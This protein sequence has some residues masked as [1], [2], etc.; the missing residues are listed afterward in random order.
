MSQKVKKKIK[1]QVQ[2]GCFG[3]LN[4]R[5]VILL[6]LI[7]SPDSFFVIYGLGKFFFFP[8]YFLITGFNLSYCQVMGMWV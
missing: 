1:F 7:V 6:A 8:W 2:C 3:Y 4:V 5:R